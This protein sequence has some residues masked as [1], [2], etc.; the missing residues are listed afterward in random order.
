M[1]AYREGRSTA[2]PILKFGTTLSCS[3]SRHGHL[4]LGKELQYPL[5]RKLGTLHTLSGRFGE[6][7]HLLPLTEFKIRIVQPAASLY[8]FGWSLKTTF[9]L[10]SKIRYGWKIIATLALLFQCCCCCCCCRR[11]FCWY[12][13]YY[14]RHHHHHNYC[15]VYLPSPLR[16]FFPL[17]LQMAALY[18]TQDLE[19]IG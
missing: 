18:I 13:Y 11:R 3:N 2:P 16:R 8:N 12:Y 7:R 19:R 15:T 10:Y 14:H 9:I 5:N 1:K 6:D 17:Y 4:T